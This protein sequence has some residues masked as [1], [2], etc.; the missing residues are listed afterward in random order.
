MEL[1]IVESPTKA[2]TIQKFLGKDFVVKATLG[3]IKDLPEK[4]LGV[5]LKTLKAKYVYRR[6]KR[7]L[8]E[9][10]KKLARRASVVYLGTDPDR[11]GEAIAYFLKKELEKM[12]K[13]LKRAIFYEITHNGKHKTSG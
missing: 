13:N 9:Q 7:K 5:D 11:E 2:R 12:N 4:E 1:F 8:I 6:G 10:L 3:H